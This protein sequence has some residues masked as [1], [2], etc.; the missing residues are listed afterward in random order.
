MKLRAGRFVTVLT[1]ALLATPLP[2]QAQQAGKVYRIGYL[3]PDSG[4]SLS[5]EAFR[6][7][8]RDLGWVEGRNI[9]IEYRWAGGRRERLADLATELV[10]LKVDIILGST[11]PGALA[12]KKATKTIPIVIPVSNDPV[13]SGLVESLARPGGNVTGFSFIAQDMTQKRLELLK[14]VDPGITRVAA[15]LNP[16]HPRS[17]AEL[18]EGEV[19][20]RE[21][22]MQ[23]Q[24]LA[25]RNPTELESAFSAVIRERADGLIVLSDRLFFNIRGRLAE[26]AARRRVPFIHYAKEFVEA[27]GLMS[28]GPN[29]TDMYQRAAILVDKILK[30]AK[31]ADLPVE[32]PTKFDLVINLKTARALG[33]T[34][35]PSVLARADQLI[36]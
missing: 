14:E 16:T 34:I 7:G 36:E 35:P 8:L 11:T 3:A 5:S 9:V 10:Q 31:P 32:Q 22:G 33:L 4:P 15:L 27:G 29:T 19:A 23:L 2:A 12:A 20:A 21:L 26:F 17:A 25:V 1:L 13:G 30:G 24:V 28:Y 6:Q 18:S